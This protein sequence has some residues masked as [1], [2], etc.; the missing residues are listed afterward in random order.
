[1]VINFHPAPVAGTATPATELRGKELHRC[2]TTTELARKPAH[3]G[4]VYKE[5]IS[6]NESK[7]VQCQDTGGQIWHHWSW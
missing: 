5:N 2:N 6:L 1:M 3:Y 4:A 7:K